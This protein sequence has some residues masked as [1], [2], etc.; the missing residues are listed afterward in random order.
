MAKKYD[1]QLLEASP[2]EQPR[3][4]PEKPAASPSTGGLF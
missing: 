2:R 3:V 1:L 4:R